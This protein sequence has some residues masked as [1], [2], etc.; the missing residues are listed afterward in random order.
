MRGRL[1]FLAVLPPTVHE[2]FT[3]FCRELL[4]LTRHQRNGSTP[5]RHPAAESRPRGRIG[6]AFRQRPKEKLMFVTAG[7]YKATAIL[8]LRSRGIDLESAPCFGAE[9]LEARWE[10]LI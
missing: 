8:A 4:L 6:L 9:P 7:R 3:L 2:R 1:A 5:E 10:C